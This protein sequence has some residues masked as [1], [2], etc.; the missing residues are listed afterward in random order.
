[1][2]KNISLSEKLL[3]YTAMTT[4]FFSAA[5]SSEAQVVYHDFIPDELLSGFSQFD[6][7]NDG[8]YDIAF[9]A[10]HVSNVMVY[11][12]QNYY[13]VSCTASIRASSY[14]SLAGAASGL[15]P[16]NSGTVID[17]NLSWI[18]SATFLLGYLYR[19]D[20]AGIY[21]A[22]GNWANTTNKFFG[23]RLKNNGG[24]Y[25]GWMRMSV[26]G[27]GC[28]VTLHDYAYNMLPDE[29]IIAGDTGTATIISAQANTS[30][31]QI[32]VQDQILYVKLD[33]NPQVKANL[34]IVDVLGRNRYATFSN[35][36]LTQISIAELEQGEFL[37]VIRKGND[38]D[39]L[40][41][42]KN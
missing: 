1:M 7:N 33:Q 34:T 25:Y 40:R 4:A 20:I 2:N 6:L 41:F 23:F 38:G 37:L 5:K 30:Q 11:N 10:A 15:A 17:D 14:N 39:V 36:S 35:Q 27:Y 24:T 12:S 16:L 22:E 31:P 32:F 26:D 19:K 18:P 28:G 13:Q 21:S 8:I 42:I 29:L 3:A 9:N